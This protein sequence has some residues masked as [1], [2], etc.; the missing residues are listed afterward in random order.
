MSANPGAPGTQRVKL[1]GIDSSAFQHS[2]DR[3]A[4]EG[5]KRLPGFDV[6]LAKF[7]EFYYE[8]AIYVY[9]IASNVKVGPKQF[10]TLYNMLRESCDILDLAEPELYVD[11]MPVVNAF[12]FGH[13][14]PFITIYTGTL[15]LMTEEETMGIIAHELGHIKCGHVLY[16]S[17][18]RILA[19][20][21]ISLAGSTFVLAL[22]VY[23]VLV[24]ALIN[25]QRLSELSADRASLLVMQNEPTVISTL[26]K[27]A[28]GTEKFAKELDP[29]E[30]LRQARIYN[31]ELDQNLLGFIYKFLASTNLSRT[32]PFAV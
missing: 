7:I 12:T 28:G 29:D 2:L 1:E 9:N 25:W 8:R 10:P 11:Q 17:M 15:E 26:T 21:A 27:L 4:T 32:H 18:S 3:Q 6:L 20:F 19:N 23:M 24:S 14:K 30:F 22:P 16:S 31:E 13:N 5:L